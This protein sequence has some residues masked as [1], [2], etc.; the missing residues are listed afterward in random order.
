[1]DTN[2]WCIIMRGSRFHRTM[3]LVLNFESNVGTYMYEHAFLC[4]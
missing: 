4:T 3:Y 2:D 1:M